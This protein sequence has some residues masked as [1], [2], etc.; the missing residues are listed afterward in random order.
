MLDSVSYGQ[1]GD[2]IETGEIDDGAVSTAKL[3]DDAVTSAK[4][5]NAVRLQ[6]ATASTATERTTAT[7]SWVDTATAWTLTP[8]DANNV[9][10]S[11]KVTAT[12]KTDGVAPEGYW[13]VKVVDAEGNI[14]YSLPIHNLQ[15]A[16]ETN[17]INF[18]GQ[19]KLGQWTD[20]G[21]YG[22]MSGSA[23]YTITIQLQSESGE[24]NRI[25]DVSIEVYYLQDAYTNT[26]AL[27]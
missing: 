18:N 25:K 7:Q 26:S 6:K 2:S 16:Y 9:I 14:T 21:G 12:S 11:L 19:S 22:A 8:S 5:A 3:A 17:T 24:T 10:Q 1:L 23:T 27:S 13:R 4:L 15:N 20:D